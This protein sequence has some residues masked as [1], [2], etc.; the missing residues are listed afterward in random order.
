MFLVD[1]DLGYQKWPGGK[2]EAGS[3]LTTVY[4]CGIISGGPLCNRN[5]SLR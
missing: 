1:L 5:S 3:R 2:W 4:A